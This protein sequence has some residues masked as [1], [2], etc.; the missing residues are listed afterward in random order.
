[1]SRTLL[2][3]WDELFLNLHLLR[4]LFLLVMVQHLKQHWIETGSHFTCCGGHDKVVVAKQPGDF[5]VHE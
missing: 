5:C 1:M 2:E 3:K 4:M